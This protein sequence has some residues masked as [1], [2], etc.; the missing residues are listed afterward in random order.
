M[1]ALILA[2]GKGSR[3]KDMNI[4]HPKGMLN[5][6]G[7][8]IIEHQIEMY[9]SVGINEIIIVR[10]Y[11]KELIQFAN[12]HF[13]DNENYDSTN[14]I[15]SLMCARSYLNDDI[16][17]SYA[18]ILFSKNCLHSLINNSH[19]IVVT[20][21]SKW[22][23]YWRQRYGS[24][25]VDLENLKIEDDHIVEIGQSMKTS[26]NIDYR[27]VGINKFSKKGMQEFIKLYDKKKKLNDN[28]SSSNNNF[29][30]GYITDMLQELI[31]D[32]ILVKPNYIQN[33]WLEIDT[34]EDYEAAK[35]LYSKKEFQ[36]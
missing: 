21:D 24:V 13:V 15:E 9:R 8:S 4:N 16:I 1:N 23:Q 10:G 2:A 26:N 20:V 3:L 18:D 5:F 25:D 11:K 14:M 12:V 36:P 19:S 17:I 35:K 7:K 6:L 31:N 29:L 28:W 34:P 30:N 22:K 32:K 33:N 27:Y